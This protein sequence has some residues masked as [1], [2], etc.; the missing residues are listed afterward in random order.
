MNA[1]SFKTLDTECLTKTVR[2]AAGRSG[3]SRPFRQQD[4]LNLARNALLAECAGRSCASP[5]ARLQ[6]LSAADVWVLRRWDRHHDEVT[7]W[8]DEE[9]AVSALADYV[10]RS[11]SNL[12]GQAGVTAEPPTDDR[13]AVRMYYGPEGERGDEDYRLYLDSIGRRGSAPA[14]E[15]QG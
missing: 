12:H 11:W 6:S 14:T 3:S 8:A 10:R 4:T 1:E 15:R 5:V 13:E 9:S 2:G 7:L